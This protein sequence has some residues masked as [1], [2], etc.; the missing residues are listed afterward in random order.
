MENVSFFHLWI[1]P[2]K[3]QK[4]RIMLL[5]V[6]AIVT[7]HMAFAQEATSRKPLNIHFK[8]RGYFYAASPQ[9]PTTSGFGGWAQSDNMYEPAGKNASGDKLILQL[10]PDE[11]R[12]FAEKFSGYAL[13]IINQTNDTIFLSS[14][15]QPPQPAPSGPRQKRKLARH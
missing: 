5:T 1:I 9:L 15:G 11:P 13:Y 2:S 6:S 12:P 14:P 4:M 7:M 8:N 10:K 3:A